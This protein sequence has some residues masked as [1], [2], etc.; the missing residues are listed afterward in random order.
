MRMKKK[1]DPARGGIK[2]IFVSLIF[3]EYFE[4]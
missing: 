1:H 2:T 3:S 4:S